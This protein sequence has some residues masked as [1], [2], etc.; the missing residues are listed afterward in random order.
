MIPLDT[1]LFTTLALTGVG[2]EQ[3]R[4]AGAGL[5]VRE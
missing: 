5:F 4:R 1:N 2:L 3:G